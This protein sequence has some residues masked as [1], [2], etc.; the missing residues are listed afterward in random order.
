M[1]YEIVVKQNTSAGYG[2]HVAFQSSKKTKKLTPSTH[3]HATPPG[4]LNRPRLICYAAGHAS[5]PPTSR[6]H[7]MRRISTLVLGSLF[8]MTT[9]L[10]AD[11][12]KVGDKAP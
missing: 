6:R 8:L 9:N 4:S 1:H 12:L 5:F 10:S 7:A 3:Q 11:E 2:N